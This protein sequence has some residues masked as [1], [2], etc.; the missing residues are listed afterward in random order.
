MQIDADAKYL[1]VCVDDD[2]EFLESV[3]QTVQRGI[4]RHPLGGR[5]ELE[6]ACG[7]G[8]FRELL[9]ELADE[10][11]ELAVLVTDQIMPESSGMELIEEIKPD[12]PH[13]SCVLLTGY[14]GLESARYAINNQLLDRYVCKPI[15]DVEAFTETVGSE[16]DRFHLRRTQALQAAEIARQDQELREA[17]RKLDMMRQTAENVAYFFREMRTLD[18]DALLDHAA[19][20]LPQLFGAQCCFMSI[21]NADDRLLSWHER[22]CSCTT[23]ASSLGDANAVLTEALSDGAFRASERR[24]PCSGAVVEDHHDHGCVVLPIRLATDG[25][26]GG[27]GDRIASLCVC[28]ITDTNTLRPEAV[29]YKTMLVNDVVGANIRNAVTHAETVRLA[30]EDGLTGIKNRRSFEEALR[31]EWERYKRHDSEFCLALIDLDRFKNIND[32]HGHD[33]GDEVLQAVAQALSNCSRQC[34]LAARFGGDE[35]VILLSETDLEGA[36]AA[37]S[38]VVAALRN[39]EFSKADAF[40]TASI[41]IASARGKGSPAELLQAADR[42]LYESKRAGRDRVS[43]A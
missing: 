24:G 41:G 7:P 35:F 40:P 1:I 28:G 21:P 23:S 9:A 2:R 6:L 22:R 32:T 15:D 34:D 4:E 17:N 27:K 16:L 10:P 36:A 13:T 18:L 14:A 39:V 3:G 19:E 8:E 25:A 26:H 30:S 33:A 42:A 43:T 12:H 31:S 5:C 37:A 29:E 11:V 38:R 20:W